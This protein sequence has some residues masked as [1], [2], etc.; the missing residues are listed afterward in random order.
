LYLGQNKKALML[1]NEIL[2]QHK[3]YLD[4][5]AGW[6]WFACSLVYQ[7][8]NLKSDAERALERSYELLSQAASKI[9]DVSFRAS[10]LA[11]SYENANIV[12]TWNSRKDK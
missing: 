11:N 5:N 7:A 4:E 10:F 2:A 9:K 8:N 3:N 12:Q 1:V 6:F